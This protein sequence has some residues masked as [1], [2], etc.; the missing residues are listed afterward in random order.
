MPYNSPEEQKEKQA[1]LRKIQLTRD[2]S[3][4]F[5]TDDKNPCKKGRIS[6]FR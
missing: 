2:R 1:E 5:G 3:V 6:F 4:T